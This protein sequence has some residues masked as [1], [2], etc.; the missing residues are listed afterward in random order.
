M[1]VTQRKATPV[2]RRLALAIHMGLFALLAGEGLAFADERRNAAGQ[3]RT[4]T[5][6]IPAQPLQQAIEQFT[7]RTGLALLYDNRLLSGLRS[8][9]L[10]GNYSPEAALDVLFGDHPLIHRRNEEGLIVLMPRPGADDAGALELDMIDI[11]AEVDTAKAGD[12]VYQQ[13]RGVSHITR[14]MIDDRPPRHAADM[15]E[16]TTGVY[17]AVNQ[18]DPG[19]SVNIRGIQDY[20]R[21]NMNIDGMRQNFNVSGHQQRNG[22]ILVDPEMIAGIDIEKGTQAGQGGAGVL[23]G[24]ATFRTFDARDFLQDGKDV[25]GRVR[26][27]HGI[28]KLSNGTHFNGSG[29]LAI[30]DERGDILLG[31]SERRFGDYKAGN[32]NDKR[33]GAK[34]FNRHFPE[35]RYKKAVQD[36]LAADTEF[37]DGTTRSHLI[38]FGLNLPNH[39]RVQA[40]YLQTGADGSTAGAEVQGGFKGYV[41]R[42]RDR[43]HAQNYALDYS[44]QPDDPW[45]DFKAKSYVV[46]NTLDRWSAGRAAS[47]YSG[48][49]VAPFDSQYNTVTWGLQAENT[50]RIDHGAW[51]RS[52]WSAGGEFFKDSFE[53]KTDWKPSE[54][55]SSTPVIIGATPQGSRYMASIFNKL[56]YEYG[57]WLTM[58]GGLRY[59]YYRTYGE[60]HATLNQ[61][62]PNGIHKFIKREVEHRYK[63]NLQE[64]HWSP[65]FGV[66]IK[67]GVDWAQVYGRWGKGWRPPSVTEAFMTGSPHVGSGSALLFPN[68]ALKPESSKNWELG[69]N[70]FKEGVL[71]ANDRFAAKVSYFDSS[72]DDMM[73]MMIGVAPPRTDVHASATNLANVNNLKQLRLRGVE[74]QLEYDIERVYAGFTYTKMIGK[75]DFCG[76]DHYLGG[77]TKRRSKGKGLYEWADDSRA[78]GM[79]S[80]GGIIGSMSYRPADRG[81]VTIGSR[82]LDRS[83][84]L[85]VRVRYSAGLGNDL[86]ENVRRERFDFSAWPSYTAYDVYGSYKVNK[87]VELMLALENATNEAYIVPKGDF[88]NL[89][90]ARGRTLTG[91]IQYTF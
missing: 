16:E 21:V 46:N 89:A 31:V 66:G 40:S 23:G 73:F 67:P 45:V 64:G 50:A 28:G 39:Q 76:Y 25:G 82:W 29:L 57:D 10:K 17:T 11:N 60:L 20:G 43:M 5:F 84:D 22:V 4:T 18:R 53:P 3:S 71:F 65:N 12:W 74:Y 32:N 15:L 81:S 54:N 51:G 9:V 13:P 37:M 61:F 55:Q 6:D 2:T 86:D 34:L 14:K 72:I 26:V 75:N 77:A 69:L 63:V 52:T 1:N 27:G 80:C 7:R 78:N 68:P 83:L 87:Q 85:G 62:P 49:Y 19:L 42:A 91:T 30:G 36:W 8:S 79:V 24:I 41:L 35:P 90:V 59:D 47:K 38:K 44:Y 56:T 33:L 88:E 48:N 58:D 70:I